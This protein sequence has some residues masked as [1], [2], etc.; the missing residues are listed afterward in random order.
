[1]ADL[2]FQGKIIRQ[3][4]ISTRLQYV[5]WGGGLNYQNGS[6]GNKVTFFH[7]VKRIE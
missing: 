1:M 3:S 5:I 4:E 6:L 2:N 7:S